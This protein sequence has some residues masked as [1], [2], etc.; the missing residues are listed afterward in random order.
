MCRLGKI[1]RIVNSDRQ[2]LQYLC[3]RWADLSGT[4]LE[5][6][7]LMR[8][9]GAICDRHEGMGGYTNKRL[10]TRTRLIRAG[11]SVVAERGVGPASIG[12]IAARAEVVAGTFYNHFSTRDEFVAAMAE[13]LARE[14]H[15]GA[16]QIRAF[17]GDPAARVALAM[18]GLVRQAGASPEFGA[19]FVEF[20]AKVP[21]L[22]ERLR[23]LTGEAI[24]EGV[25][26]G[27]FTV[28]PGPEATDAVIGLT[29][30][31]VRSQATGRTGSEAPEAVAILALRMLG[32][33]TD[34]IHTIVTAAQLAARPKHPA[35]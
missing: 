3:W 32:L 11:I 19:A 18:I 23:R 12:E 25:Q 10:Q 30:E 5:S 16:D 21:A 17:E 29:V 34:H 13:E 1:D 24:A 4:F 22:G 33:N 27:R 28:T 15:L 8:G 26:R 35:E 20:V 6:L 14:V 7:L 9:L 31:A 2:Y